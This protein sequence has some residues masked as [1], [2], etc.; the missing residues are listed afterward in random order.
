[1]LMRRGLFS[2]SLCHPRQGARTRFVQI[3]K[4]RAASR[5]KE[6]RTKRNQRK[7]RKDQR[8]EAN[9]TAAELDHKHSTAARKR[10]SNN[11]NPVRNEAPAGAEERIRKGYIELSFPKWIKRTLKR[12]GS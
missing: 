5:R 3:C 11:S 9:N 2:S 8:I 7:K 1:M 6:I 10:E 4:T 12:S